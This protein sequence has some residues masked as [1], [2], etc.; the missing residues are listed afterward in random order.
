MAVVKGITDEKINYGGHNRDYF[1][2][3]FHVIST[4]SKIQN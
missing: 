4:N 1:Q 3:N 2:G